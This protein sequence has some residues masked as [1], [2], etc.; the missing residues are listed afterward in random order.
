MVKYAVR[1]HQQAQESPQLAGFFRSDALLVP[2]PGSMPNSCGSSG[3]QRLLRTLCARGLGAMAWPGLHR[4]C[5]V[6][7]SATAAP[8]S[9]PSVALHYQSFLMD[10]PRDHMRGTHRRCGDEGRT[11][12]AAALVCGR[13]FRKRKF[14]RLRCCEPGVGSRGRAVAGPLHRRNPLEGGRCAPQPVRRRV[15]EGKGD[16]VIRGDRSD[17]IAGDAQDAR[18]DVSM[19]KP[20]RAAAPCK[21]ATRSRRRLK[22]AL[23]AR[24]AVGAHCIHELWMRGEMSVTIERALETIV[25]LRRGDGS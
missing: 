18:A 12:L 2:V 8:G 15:V 21:A 25:G 24:T 9:R 22:R 1:V 23:D 16:R 14:E 17:R 19:P 13:R 4:I 10:R 20:R 3:W 11:L 6:R 7:K 5:P